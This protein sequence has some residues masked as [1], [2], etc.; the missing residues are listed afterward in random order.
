MRPEVAQ[1]WA[2][3]SRDASLRYLDR[4]GADVLRDEARE[5]LRCP[6]PGCE[7]DRIS[8][9]GGSRRDHFFHLTEGA[10]HTDGESVFHLQAK[11]MLAAWAASRASE[12]EVREEQ[13]VKDP[14]TARSR[15]P[16]VL[17]S[18]L[19]G[20][21]VAFEVEYKSWPVQ[22]WRA[23]QDDL[24]ALTPTVRAVWLFGHLHRYLA[25]ERRPEWLR[26]DGPWDRVLIRELPRAVAAAG[27][28]VLHVNPIDRTVGTVVID[29][30]PLG[31]AR[32]MR[33]WWRNG[34]DHVG[35]RL[36]GQHDDRGRL[37]V[38]HIDECDLDP[39]LGLVTPAMADAARARE[40]I[41]AAVVEDE[42][43]DRVAAG[44]ERAAAERRKAEYERDR[45]AREA[46]RERRKEYALA[47][48][49]RDRLRWRDDPLRKNLVAHYGRVPELLAVRLDDDRG[50][51]GHHEHWHCVAFRDLVHGRVGKVWT[52]R[53]VYAVIAQHFPLHKDAMVRGPAISGFLRHLR[54][55]GLLE[56][57]DWG[58]SIQSDVSVVSDDPVPLP[59]ARGSAWQPP[60]QPAPAPVPIP[61]VAPPVRQPSDRAASRAG[62]RQ[63]RLQTDA[64]RARTVHTPAPDLPGAPSVL[65]VTVARS[66]ADLEAAGLAADA[67][68]ALASILRTDPA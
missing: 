28:P 34:T 3:D 29:G 67:A 11:A 59:P 7:N 25:A 32:Q 15:R 48:A 51:H 24:D 52:V 58:G 38:C 68:A 46:S 39:A 23:K 57:E 61:V 8:T 17:A 43:R 55:Y 65:P 37:V 60:A 36:P 54:E 44:R 50:V 5:F 2:V 26:G 1:V 40:E 56:F 47:A 20:Q 41:A 66:V 31:E 10:G 62:A 22:S 9:R 30:R 21:R 35:L 45:E 63:M 53:Q 18:W 14:E 27:M 16:D 33:G 13:T 19:G 49:E 12:A 6:V 64:T 4:G 42:E